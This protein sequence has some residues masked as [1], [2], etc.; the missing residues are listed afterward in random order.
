[1]GFVFLRLSYPL[2]LHLLHYSLHLFRRRV[3]YGR[4]AERV[5]RLPPQLEY[6]RGKPCELLG[7]RNQ[8]ISELP[9]SEFHPF[10]KVSHYLQKRPGTLLPEQILYLVETYILVSHRYLSRYILSS[11]G[12]TSIFSHPSLLTSRGSTTST[13]LTD[14][15]T[16]P[17]SEIYPSL[18]RRHV[19]VP[20]RIRMGF[21]EDTV[22]PNSHSRPHQGKGELPL[23]S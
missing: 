22:T 7:G 4:P 21:H 15:E 11:L 10:G 2:Q 8:Q 3:F 18:Q 14:K 17:I 13:K 20:V 19:P 6:P 9:L 1:M 12:L 5:H 16:L 23:P